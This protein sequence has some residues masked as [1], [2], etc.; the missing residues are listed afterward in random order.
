MVDMRSEGRRRAALGDVFV[1]FSVELQRCGAA[2]SS[3]AILDDE[4][5]LLQAF[6]AVCDNLQAPLSGEQDRDE[7]ERWSLE[8]NTWSLLRAL[9]SERL[10]GTP[11][12]P[13]S[14]KNPYTP[15]LA[16]AQQLI[17]SR[18]DLL[19]LSAIR[20]WLHEIHPEATFAANRTGYAPYTKNK[21]KQL[22]RTGAPPP[23]GLVDRL[24]PDAL[25]R[26]KA[27]DE[28][29]R[30][31]A[32]DAS[33]ERAFL[34]SLYEYLRRGQLDLAIES[35]RQSDQSWRAASLSGGQLWSDPLLAA[36]DDELEEDDVMAGP[37]A[38]E[39][40]VKGNANRKLWK[41]M[42]RKL[43]GSQSLDKFERALYG[44]LSGDVASVLPV[45]SGWEDVVWA[46][47]NSLFESRV[48]AGL[49]AS[50]AG[51]FWQR[52]SVA[53]LNA[54]A[55]LDPEDALIGPGAAT[56]RPLRAELEEVFDKLVRSDKADLSAAAK[57][58]FRVAQAYLIV[59]KV[60]DLL[61]TFVDRLEAAALDT[62]PETLAH[63]LRFFSHLVLV[64]RMLK[65]PLPE[66][67]SNRILEAYVHV[68]EAN[69]QDEDLIA[70][71][72]SHLEK[73]SAI[74]SY[75]RFLLTFDPESDIH[76]RQAA[77][78]KSREHGLSLSLIARRTVEL[79]LSSTLATLPPSFILPA[80]GL[81][82][83]GRL[84]GRQLDLI[85]S[86]EWLTA[87]QETYQDAIQEA[88]ALTRW[89]LVSDAPHAARELARR[90]P[91]NLL[92][93]L[94]ASNPDAA[95][96]L[97]IREHLDYVA[98]F[99]CFDLHGEWMQ[100][101]ARRPRTKATK[102]EVA[103]YR[104][105]VAAVVDTLYARAVELLEGDWLKLEGLDSTVD[106]AA[107]RRQTEL[108]RIRRLVVPDVVFRLHR[109]LFESSQIIPE[110]LT[111][112]LALSTLIADER[113]QLYLEFVAA[114][115]DEVE[116][117]PLGLKAYLSEICEASLAS[118]D[119]GMGPVG[120]V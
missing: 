87:E 117:A 53:P 14:S 92:H 116:T 29:A 12:E 34:R 25:V 41:T 26:A 60:G 67:A 65:Q 73:Q 106:A 61:E 86:L 115:P 56:G 49:A 58:P 46:H 35:C 42:C 30:L 38:L 11:S 48:E 51:R 43:A 81:N 119:R 98:L 108:A 114:T 39:R 62:E 31:E 76:A 72:A 27:E 82:A 19:E 79:I 78:R 32:E 20:D 104:D 69:D 91:E 100:L 10:S 54:K 4:D 5:G 24:D 68:L 36:D 105:E 40:S 70:F 113:F 88:N 97:D 77:L 83:F 101:W 28:G 99:A 17:E 109:A 2:P 37:G 55:N 71:Y 22:S 47:V 120:V 59:G 50:P 110:N 23:Q 1:D 102:I 95:V 16:V 15:P 80:S 112:C 74:E 75:A 6:N 103:Q 44:A 85:R 8:S 66:F 118:L 33:Y 94:A 7:Y 13:S 64:L 111:R 21:L 89:F 84:D 18:K 93:T 90:L 96:Q 57:N 3:D 45:C 52:G 63:L 9:Y 107:S